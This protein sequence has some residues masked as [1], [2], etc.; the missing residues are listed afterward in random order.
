MKSKHLIMS[1][2]VALACL[3]GAAWSGESMFDS[4]TYQ[5]LVADQKAYKVGDA[6]TV[7]IQESSTASSTVDAKANRSTDVGISGQVTGHPQKGVT[8]S[9]NSGGDGGGQTNRSGR[10]TA[11]IT[12]SVVGKDENGELLIKGEQS[13]E[14]NGE[15]QVISVAG[16]VRPRDISDGNAVLS[17]RIADAR[18]TYSGQGYLSD[19]SKPSVLSRFFDFIGL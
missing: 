18:I 1:A 7:L 5:A 4:K 3:H 19:K 13:V 9:V 12:V 11:Q 8:A 17:S 15:A 6:L 14:L 16:R 2:A 10:V